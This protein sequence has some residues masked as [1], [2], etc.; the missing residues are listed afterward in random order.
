[1]T[2]ANLEQMITAFQAAHAKILLAGITL[3]RN[4]GDDYIRDFE[5]V[6]TDLAAKHRLP[7]LPFLLEGVAMQPGLMQED[8]IHPTAAGNEKVAATVMKA[9][10]PLLR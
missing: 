8:G 5:K 4:Y 3:P 10:E 2:R 6:Y 9:L 1:M 7:F